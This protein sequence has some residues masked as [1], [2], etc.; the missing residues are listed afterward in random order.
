[1]SVKTEVAAN[2]NSACCGHLLGVKTKWGSQFE[3]AKTEFT[4]L[5]GRT[6]VTSLELPDCGYPVSILSSLSVNGG[7]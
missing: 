3:A 4:F 1:M 7:L 5:Y 6:G 2:Y